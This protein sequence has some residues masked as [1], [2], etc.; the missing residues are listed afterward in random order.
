MTTHRTKPEMILDFVEEYRKSG[1]TW[2]ATKQDIASWAIRN[3]KWQPTLKSQ[4]NICA[5]EIADAM[6]EDLFKDAQRRTVRRKYAMPVLD[7]L[8]DGRHKQRFL[9]LDMT[10][11]STTTE[12][13]H[14]VFQHQR[15]QVLND[16]VQLKNSVDS[17]NENFNREEYIQL[18]L[19]FEPDIAELAQPVEYISRPIQ[20]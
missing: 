13:M 9:W 12:Q 4:I 8:P 14:V 11:E 16:C 1:E 5:D 17:Y 2:P 19:N 15:K 18:C 20:D 3:D 7:S 6:R 10:D